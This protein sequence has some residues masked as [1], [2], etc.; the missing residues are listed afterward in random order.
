MIDAVTPGYLRKA[1]DYV[2]L[3]PVRTELLRLEEPLEKWLWSSCFQCLRPAHVRPDRLESATMRGDES[4]MRQ[5]N[6]TG[7]EIFTELVRKQPGTE[8][9]AGRRAILPEFNCNRSLPDN[10]DRRS[11]L[12]VR[13]LSSSLPA[14]LPLGQA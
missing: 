7:D 3:H 1:C 4:D 14:A 13:S 8:K 9:L 2:H 12:L 6:P 5:D 11:D 10:M